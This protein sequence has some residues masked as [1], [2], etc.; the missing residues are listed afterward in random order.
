MPVAD[1]GPLSALP[2]AQYR[3]YSRLRLPQTTVTHASFPAVD[4]HAHLGRWLTGER[5]AVPD[6]AA[7]VDL[8]DSCRIIAVVNLDG[9]WGDELEENL[10]RY[11][12]SHPG[13]FA[14]FCH[15]D[16]ALLREPGAEAKLAGSLERSVAA[17]ARGLKVWKDLGLRVQDAGGRLVLPDDPR[18]DALWD[19]AGRLGV[20]V[21]IH[22]ADPVAFFDPV[23]P[24][25]ERLEELLARPDWSFC[26]PRYPRF[27]RLMA[28]LEAIVAAHPATTFIAVHAG[29]YAEDLTWVGAMMEKYPNFH[30]DIAARI[31]ELGRQ[32]RAT[33]SLILG[34]PGRVLFGTDEIPPKRAV[35]EI[36]FR[37][38]KRRTSAFPTLPTTRRA[39]A[40]GRSRPL[41]FPARSCNR[42]T[43][44]TPSGSSPAWPPRSRPAVR[45]GHGP[46]QQNARD[47]LAVA[48]GG[49]QVA[50]R[51]QDVERGVGGPAQIARVR[52]RTQQD[53]L[54]PGTPQRDAGHA[55]DGDPGVGDRAVLQR[56]L[57]GHPGHGEVAAPAAHLLEGGPRTGRGGR[58]A[59]RGQELVGP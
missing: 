28:A 48:R 33:Q 11:D 16:W 40:A 46:A 15:V 20:P 17:G 12:R 1:Q 58:E 41:I 9:R 27:D 45:F 29:C 19:A 34:H 52:G 35:Y 5:W 18:L 8:M 55:A 26:D 30:I 21:A 31:A 51:V 44:T 49:V 56:H 50:G 25:N 38:W 47:V 23:D 7:F 24:R 10:D 13:R 59:D 6:V 22:T 14:T 39:P 43:R 37:S 54:R 4:A 36:Y 32:P 2:L 53:L 42:S 3:P 57:D